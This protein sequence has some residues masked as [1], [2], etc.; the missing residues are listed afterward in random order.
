M[1]DLYRR[2]K[3]YRRQIERNNRL[4]DQAAGKVHPEK[5][6]NNMHYKGKRYPRSHQK[7]N[8]VK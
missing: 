1:R 4:A 7:V 6:A 8:R 2:K 5:P 3:F